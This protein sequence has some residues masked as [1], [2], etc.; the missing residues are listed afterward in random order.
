M[1]PDSL[2]AQ[3]SIGGALVGLVVAFVTAILAGR[4]IPRSVAKLQID[5]ANASAEHW[6]KAYEAS[7]SRGDISA[8]QTTQLLTGMQILTEVVRSAM[9]PKGQ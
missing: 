2:P 5:Q 8:S 3:L 6:R 7:E 1:W 4:L 9:P